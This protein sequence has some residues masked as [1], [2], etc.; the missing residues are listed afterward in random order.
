MVPY[1]G[2]MRSAYCALR[3]APAVTADMEVRT[4]MT[5]ADPPSL[6]KSKKGGWTLALS[7][8]AIMSLRRGD[9][10]FDLDRP[11]IE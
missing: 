1:G 7:L 3:A 4:R 11:D 9:F 2:A 8:I 5:H 6:L 10:L